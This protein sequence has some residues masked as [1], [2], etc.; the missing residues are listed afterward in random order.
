M[1]KIIT[2]GI[3]FLALHSYSQSS[4]SDCDG[5][6]VLCNDV[7]SEDQA[8][9]N[10]GNLVE[11]TGNCNGFLEQSS[12]WYTFTVQEN[13][14]LAFTLTPNTLSDD[15]DWG[16]FD[17]TSGGCA[18]IG[19]TSLEVSCNSWGTLSGNNGAT[20]ISSAQGGGANT[21]GPG[22]T[23]GPPF[24]AD[25]TVT[26]GTTYALVVMN[27]TNSLDGYTIDFG[28]STASLY[29]NVP[30]API[31]VEVSCSNN[32]LTLNF[33]EPIVSSSVQTLDF[34]ITDPNGQPLDVT[35]AITFGGN[36]Q[37]DQIVIDLSESLQVEGTYTLTITDATG[38]VEDA[39]GN[40]G[41][42]S[43]TFDVVNL[44]T[45]EIATTT[46]CNGDNGSI[47]IENIE[48]GS[49]PYT[50]EINGN[51]QTSEA[52]LNLSNG[53]YEIAVVQQN[54]CTIT[55]NVTVPNS[56]ISLS[57][58][59]QDTLSCLNAELSIQN[60]NVQGDAPFTFAWT[61]TLGLGIQE[62]SNSI[63][64]LINLPGI[65]TLEVTNADGCTDEEAV[66]IV[67]GELA[68]VDL[69]TIVF[70]NIFTPNG[71]AM[72]PNWKPFLRSNPALDLMQV[73]DEY[74][75][76]VYNRWGT[77]VFNTNGTPKEFD[78]SDLSDGTYFYHV[79]YATNCGNGDS[80]I[81]EGTIYVLSGK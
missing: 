15:Y 80:G 46:A 19:S 7:Y 39:C 47:T 72:N 65:Y 55:Q 74:N 68:I 56:L 11:F 64:P 1:N 51:S 59:L 54:G 26:A 62:G 36:I 63:S 2:I 4:I 23:N 37:D 5:A 52:F 40:L 53:N 16:L 69:S 58:P 18:G 75:L 20:G 10:T 42:G 34:E 43:I 50:Y 6:I 66:E 14:T 60:V 79:E 73:L 45:F 28:E 61:S 35:G 27:W 71:D 12:V 48:G 57:I 8:S 70:P 22:D 9:F 25:L 29:D 30:P 3:V 44:L 78:A 31:S 76:V 33:S 49:A 32:S 81:K 21:G 41:E 67:E 17:I 13:G 77:E 24:N 38:L